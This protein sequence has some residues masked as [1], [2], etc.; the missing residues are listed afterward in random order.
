[1]DL[2]TATNPAPADE[3]PAPEVE[4]APE[5][6][7]AEEGEQ[8]ALEDEFEEL[9]VDGKRIKFSK[10][11]KPYVMMHADYT[12]KTQEVAEMKRAAE[13]Q[14][15]E[16]KRE[17][18]FQEENLSTI[19][20]LTAVSSQLEAFAKIDFNQLASED[21]DNAQRLYF[22]YQ[23]LK[24]AQRELQ[25]SIEGKKREWDTAREQHI[26]TA[27]RQAS[28]AL[29]RPDPGYGWGGKFTPELKTNLDKLAYSLGYNDQ[30]LAHAEAKDIKLFNLALIGL[31]ALK[32]QKTAQKAAP[33][34]EPVPQAGKGKSAAVTNP[35]KLSPE[36][37]VKW[38][39]AQIRKKEGR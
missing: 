2:D 33:T 21:Q 11:A 38:R 20:Q 31:N 18:Q 23:Q 15:E 1:M 12:R 16:V 39:E 30:Q 29:A 35:D 22:Q 27:R 24:D 36:A 19:A 25:S 10:D 37:W 26:A 7:P 3:A 9:D 13:A 14:H 8:P 6:E 5:T 4:E 34:A 17:R 32:Q 28:E